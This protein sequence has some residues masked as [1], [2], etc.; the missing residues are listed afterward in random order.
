M[1][2]V[3]N[4]MRKKIP[5]NFMWEKIST[6][7]ANFAKYIDSLDFFYKILIIVGL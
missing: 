6:V 5:N 7:G 1:T 2:K 4:N 3:S